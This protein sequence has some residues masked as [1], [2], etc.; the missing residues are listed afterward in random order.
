[1]SEAQ[2]LESLWAGSFGD[3]YVARNRGFA[4][5][6][7]FWD[8]VMIHTGAGSVLEVGCNVGG[9]LC[10]LAPAVRTVGIDVNA[11]ALTEARTLCP[12][13]LA[14]ARALPFDSGS[15]DLVC[16]VGVLIHQPD[17]TLGDVMAEM[18]RC[19]A[20]WV[21]AAEYHAPEPVEIAYR[22]QAGAL[23]KRDYGALLRTLPLNLRATG[24]LARRH[25]WDDVTWWLLE[26][27][28]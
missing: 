5:R 23:F 13:S 26:K 22:G 9:N 11:T 3:D 6:R 10:H 27:G 28:A 24:F 21:L 12:V 18:V 7:D 16:T 2:R 19:S 14:A 17:D 20:R 8:L 4:H 1:M 25:G 15:F